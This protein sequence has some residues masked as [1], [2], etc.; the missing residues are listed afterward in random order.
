MIHHPVLVI[1]AG[2]P[3]TGK[4][5]LA[6]RLADDVHLPVLHRDQLKTQIYDA[7]DLHP[8]VPTARLTSASTQLLYTFA[9]AVLHVGQSMIIEAGFLP[10][11]ATQELRALQQRVAFLSFQIQCYAEGHVL[12]ERFT[13]RM[14]MR[15][16][17]H[18]D[19]NYLRQRRAALLQGRWDSLDIGGHLFALDTSNFATVDYGELYHALKQVL[20]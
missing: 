19:A 15:H 14:G 20:L 18:P 7:L 17:A 13:A 6:R 16:A 5:T 3:A 2:P 8:R 9:E 1:V 4:T 10:E 12:V 11:L